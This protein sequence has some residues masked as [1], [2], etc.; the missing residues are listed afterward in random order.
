MY[1]KVHFHIKSTNIVVANNLRFEPKRVK[2]VKHNKQ[3]QIIDNFS[4]TSPL[5]ILN[6]RTLC[7]FRI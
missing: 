6:H 2:L 3:H 1:D 5:L 7:G 4:E